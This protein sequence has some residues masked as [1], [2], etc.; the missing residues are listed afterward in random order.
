MPRV[1]FQGHCLNCVFAI[2]KAVPEWEQILSS[3]AACQNL[4]IAANALGF[5]GQWITEWY[6]YDANV[7]SALAPGYR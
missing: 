5:S 3:G 1:K 4:L 7:R 6:A 2:G